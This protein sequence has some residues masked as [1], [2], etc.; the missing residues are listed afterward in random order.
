MT[1]YPPWLAGQRVTAALLTGMQPQ[2]VIKQA[3]ETVTSSIT[4]QDDDELFFPLE[5]NALYEVEFVLAPGGVTT[6]DIKTRW[7]VPSGATGFKWC[8]G[9]GVSATTRDDGGNIKMAVHGHGTDCIYGTV[10]T[11]SVGAS[12]EIG[13]VDTSSTP[14]NLVLQWTQN[15]S[16]A[17]GS[18]ILAG[19]YLRVLRIG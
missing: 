2:Y 8:V 10:S 1:L 9:L 4:Y 14:G 15:T 7:G 6:G 11:T 12:R 16:N 5:A 18:K 3:D 17:T 13:F 19:S